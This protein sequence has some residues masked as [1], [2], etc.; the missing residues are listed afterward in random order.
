MRPEL[1][2]WVTSNDDSVRR[3]VAAY[4][5]LTPAE[6]ARVLASACRTA[7]KLLAARPDAAEVLA[8]RDP[9]P[10]STVVALARLRGSARVR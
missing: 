3:E 1:P 9:L 7:A 4:R 10:E 5:D 6:R 8:F 2:G